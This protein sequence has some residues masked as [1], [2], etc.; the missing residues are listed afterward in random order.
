MMSPRLAKLAAT[1]D[2]QAAAIY[3][4]LG[5]AAF[6]ITR[7][8]LGAVGWFDENFHPA[9]DE[10]LDFTRRADLVGVPRVD[11]GFSGTHVGSATIHSDPSLRV[12]NGLSHTANDRYYSMKWG[13]A[14]QGGETYSTPFDRHGHVGEWRLDPERLRSQT[15]DRP[16]LIEEK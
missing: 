11:V 2:P 10:D 9:Y 14:K 15:W 1:V 5:L 6:A 16:V 3:H 7:Y 12:Q 8:T 4:M 13:G